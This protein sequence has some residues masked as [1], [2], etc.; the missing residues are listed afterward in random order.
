[1]NDNNLSEI[2]VGVF[3]GLIRL[4]YLSL[5][6]NRLNRVAEGAFDDLKELKGIMAE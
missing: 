3:R 5:E 6:S 4:E 2:N 1:M